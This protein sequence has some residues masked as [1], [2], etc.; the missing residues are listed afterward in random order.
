MK[1]F[2]Y[3]KRAIFILLSLML[4]ASCEVQGPRYNA[5]SAEKL[6][7][8]AINLMAREVSDPAWRLSRLALLDEYISATEQ[9]RKT[10][11]HLVVIRQS[12][13]NIDETTYQVDGFGIVATYGES[14]RSENCHWAFTHY[15]GEP[16]NVISF[17]YLGD[18]RWKD[19]RNWILFMKGCSEKG[20]PTVE[21]EPQDVYD[22]SVED[23]LEAMMKFNTEKVSITNPSRWDKLINYSTFSE[24]SIEAS[25]RIEISHNGSLKDWI[26]LECKGLEKNFKTSREI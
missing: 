25:V 7:N 18:E 14:F 22:T 3:I 15:E 17:K 9:E 8:Y 5:V 16:M 20:E 19:E 1:I 10:L 11:P 2:E 26:D 6:R 21:L 13:H 23:G 24:A 4:L 12:I